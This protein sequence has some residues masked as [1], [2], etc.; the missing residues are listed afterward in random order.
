MDPAAQEQV[1]RAIQA[2][3]QQQ[4][5]RP[6]SQGEAYGAHFLGIGGLRA[7]LSAPPN[8]DAMQ[9]YA[10]AAG[11]QIAQQAFRANPGLLEPGMTVGQVMDRLNGRMGG[12]GAIPASAQG[13]GQQR[14]AGGMPTPEQFAQLAA[15]A[16]AGN[17]V[18]GR[19]VQIW[20]PFM[21]QGGGSEPLETIE[22]PDGRPVL[23]PR[24]QAAG[25]TPVRTP[26]VQVNMPAGD[27]VRG[28]ADASVL[29]D[30][31]KGAND[32]RQLLALFD[33]ADRAVRAVPEGQG[34]QL[35][36]IVGQAA[37]ALGIDIQGT[38]ESEVLRSI[39]NGLAVL[40]RAPGSGA[41]TDFEMRLYMQAVPRLG[42]T[43]EGNLRL[44]DMGRRLARRRMEEAEVWRRHA[45]EPDLMERLN[46]LPPVFSE[47]DQR[48]LGE[49]AMPAASPG[50]GGVGTAEPP[51][52]AAPS[53]PRARNAQG[54]TLE[55]NGSAW[56][57]VQ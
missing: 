7:F 57:P 1:A 15:Q 10:Q 43:R 3:A 24:S 18:A 13:G 54:Q 53:R 50:P 14:P 9:V 48:F 4:I 42:N 36:P 19:L 44:I 30:V 49:D 17:E 29:P 37:R 55:Y 47:E 56:V 26:P 52:A 22:G 21:R 5:G 34:A 39:T 6:L 35:L 31:M 40:Q 46:A 11:P 12:G 20:G 8:A 45:G 38:S 41:T 28:R 27:T 32:A 25:R 2:D 51:A 16:A 33:R 23:V